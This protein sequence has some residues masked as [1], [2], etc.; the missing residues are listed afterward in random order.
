[1]MKQVQE[2]ENMSLIPLEI[3]TLLKEFKEIVVDHLIA[4]LR[5]LRS[6]SHQIDLILGSSIPNK[7]PY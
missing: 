1:M 2:M 6:I 5:P 3:Q 7:D 4:G